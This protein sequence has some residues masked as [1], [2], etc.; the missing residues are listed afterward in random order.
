MKTIGSVLDS[1]KGIGPGFDFL[2]VAL[3]ITVILNHSFLTVEGNYDA[4]DRYGIW[5]VMGAPVPMFFVLSG[6]LVLGSALRL[7]IKDFILNRAFRII[8]A[9][10]VDIFLSALVIG[11]LVTTVSLHD[12]VTGKQFLHYFLNIIGFIHYELPGVFLSNPFPGQVN[13][14]M[15]TVPLEMGSYTIMSCLILTG[16]VKSKSRLVKAVIAFMC[17]VYGLHVYYSS[18]VSPFEADTEINHYITNFVSE[19]GG[20]L[21]CYFLAGSLLYAFRYQVPYSGKL[22]LL[23]VVLYVVGFFVLGKDRL[24]V[25]AL[26]VSYMVAYIGLTPIKKLPLY[27][28]GDYSY[29]MYLYGYPLQ[30]ALVM[31]FPGRFSVITH[32]IC[33]MVLITCVAR[34]SWHCVEKPILR[35]RK[36]VSFTARK[37]DNTLTLPENEN[38]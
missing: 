5:P 23:A 13:G 36:K 19:L 8:P 22:A 7:K 31:L 10:S 4:F 11:P 15:W 20:T 30:Q 21:Y 17:M 18:H 9:L 26:P 33:S 32:F 28:K 16:A 3:A 38:V 2:R 12:Y 37:G 35:S 29:G 24:V 34:V 14:S 6:F 25:L 27:S 1:Y